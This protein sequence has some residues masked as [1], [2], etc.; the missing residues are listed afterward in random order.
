LLLLLL[1]SQ[2]FNSSEIFAYHWKGGTKGEIDN[3]NS[4]INGRGTINVESNILITNIKKFQH[5]VRGI[6]LDESGKPLIGV[7]VR[8]KNTNIITSTNEEGKY[9]LQTPDIEDGILEF[10]HIGYL[11]KEIHIEGKSNIDVVLFVD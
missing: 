5:E 3:L 9:I 6:I 10:S 2:L 4:Q 8:V 1:S 7:S 11:T